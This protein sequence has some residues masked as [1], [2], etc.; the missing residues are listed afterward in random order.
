MKALGRKLASE[1]HAKGICKEW[2]YRLR[3]TN[4]MHTL[5]RM[6]LEGIDFCIKED[7]PSA[8]FFKIFDGIRQR[9]GIFMDEQINVKDAEYVVAFGKCAGMA[10]YT[11]YSAG[12]IFVKHESELTIAVSCNSFVMVD[13]F[14]DSTVEISG[15]DNAKI[16]VNQY[17]GN[18]ITTADNENVVIKVIH[19]QSKT[20]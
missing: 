5:V 9:Y 15:Y 19:K 1:A 12:Q 11:D 3:E 13:M 6:F 4:D 10:E 18:L 8:K 17:G 14:D 20:Y 7:Y 2:Y 16:I